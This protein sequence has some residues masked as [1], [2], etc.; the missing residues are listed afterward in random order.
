MYIKKQMEV[1][2]KDVDKILAKVN[3]NSE[4]LNDA[5]ELLSQTSSSIIH[6]NVDVY[7]TVDGPRYMVGFSD[8]KEPTA[9]LRCIIHELE[10]VLKAFE[11]LQLEVVELQKKISQPK[12][13]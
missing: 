9:S 3:K 1:R 12:E 7:D 5:L 13:S 4:R 6:L 11:D 2:M 10:D 8:I